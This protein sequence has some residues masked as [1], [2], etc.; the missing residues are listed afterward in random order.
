MT[1]CKAEHVATQAVPVASVGCACHALMFAD[2]KL[3]PLLC[4]CHLHVGAMQLIN[5]LLYR[6]RQ[7]GFLELD[8]LV[9]LWAEQE[10]PKMDRGMLQEFATVLDQASYLDSS[11]LAAMVAVLFKHAESTSFQS[12]A[13]VRSKGWLFLLICWLSA[14]CRLQKC[15]MSCDCRCAGES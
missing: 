4:S 14:A 12:G 11:M 8:L 10:V 3:Y 1:W 5:K 2:A 7:R 9:G 15:K 13:T 6:S